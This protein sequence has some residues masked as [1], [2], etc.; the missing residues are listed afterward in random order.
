MASLCLIAVPVIL[1]IFVAENP[2]NLLH[3]P[4]I[5]IS[6]WVFSLLFPTVTIVG[7]VK[8]IQAKSSK[9]SKLVYWHAVSVISACLFIALY[10]AYY[11][12][13]GFKLWA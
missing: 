1:V 6:V 8:L 9:S 3:Y 11:N 10:L 7:L 5:G 13:L 2:L 4:V 12:L